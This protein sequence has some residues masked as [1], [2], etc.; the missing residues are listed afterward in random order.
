MSRPYAISA[1]QSD[2]FFKSNLEFLHFLESE[3]CTLK[4]AII[5][6]LNKLDF[7]SCQSQ[8]TT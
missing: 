6:R 4:N 2:D 3:L 7:C 5:N 1:V 8:G